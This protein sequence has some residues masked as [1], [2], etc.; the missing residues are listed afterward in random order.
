MKGCMMTALALIVIGVTLGM[1]GRSVAGQKVVEQAF[2]RMAGGS[3]WSWHNGELT[4]GP[5]T[6][7]V[8]GEDFGQCSSSWEEETMQVQAGTAWETCY[9]I[10]EV[11]MFDSNY[12]IV[13]GDVMRYC[14]GSDIRNLDI[15]VGGGAFLVEPS[16]DD[17]IYLEAYG[18]RK[19]QGYTEG[20]TLYVKSVSEAQW[21][22]EDCVILYL[23]YGYSFDKAY[24][25]AGAGNM[26]FNDLNAEAAC[27]N[28]GAGAISLY[29]VQV[30][31]LEVSV[32]A[33]SI[34]MS[35]VEVTN[36]EAEVGLGRF[37][38]IDAVINGDVSVECSMGNVEL[39]VEGRERDFNYH[40]DGAMGNIEVDSVGYISNGF[41]QKK[42]VDNNANKKMEIE[43][44][45]GN[46]T[47]WFSE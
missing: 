5:E 8:V 36:L 4:W 45:M 37:L 7:L 6:A 38:A 24:I 43:C 20:D 1:I 23:P 21:N 9:D 35:E 12:T 22:D 2:D 25:D 26:E 18:V 16:W 3:G 42:T 40:L 33:G 41:S 30:Q 11:T 19:F 15:E 13:N 31:E 27:V 32:G 46:V 47:I 28:I 34:E 44:S 29:G 17:K 10:D 39:N 14:P